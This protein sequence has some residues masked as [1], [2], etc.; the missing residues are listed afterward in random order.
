MHASSTE[1]RQRN[2]QHQL[3]N[4][5]SKAELNGCQPSSC[6]L[7]PA[8][9]PCPG[10]RCGGPHKQLQVVQ[11]HRRPTSWTRS[12]SCAEPGLVAL[13]TT[14]ES[15]WSSTDPEQLGRTAFVTAIISTCW[16]RNAGPTSMSNTGRPV[17]RCPCVDHGAQQRGHVEGGGVPHRP[18][19]GVAAGD[20]EPCTFSKKN[21]FFVFSLEMLYFHQ[22]VTS[23]SVTF[24]WC[25][26]TAQRI[27]TTENRKKALFC[28]LVASAL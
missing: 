19:L 22:I 11:Q 12:R 10:C 21:S 3:Q 9:P 7:P 1:S 26:S 25:H 23:N 27:P 18:A 15:A 24:G 16:M 5:V 13:V 14:A 2:S 20:P 4:R 17:L 8:P 6:L 28:R